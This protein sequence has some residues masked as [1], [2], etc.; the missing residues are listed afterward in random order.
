MRA[1][2]RVSGP[3]TPPATSRASPTSTEAPGTTNMARGTCSL[4]SRIRSAQNA[5]FVHHGREAGFMHRPS[6]TST[7]YG[8]DLK[9]QASR[10]EARW[11]RIV[12]RY[13]RDAAGNLLAKYGAMGGCWCG[14]S[15]G[16]PAGSRGPWRPARAPQVFVATP[17]PAGSRPRPQEGLVRSTT[18]FRQPS[19]RRAQRHWC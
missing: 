19:A 12:E 11:N 18:I 13:T 15:A 14:R 1:G 8:Y 7:V 17:I 6:G 16:E 10:G 4:D 2:A 5:V 9:D 3:T